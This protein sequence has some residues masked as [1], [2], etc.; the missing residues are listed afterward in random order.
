VPQDKG[1][2]PEELRPHDPTDAG[3][4]PNLHWAVQENRSIAETDLAIQFI[5]QTELAVNR[6]AVEVWKIIVDKKLPLNI[7]TSYSGFNRND[8]RSWLGFYDGISNI[9]S[10][11]RRAA[12]EVM[13]KNP[14]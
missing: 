11:E 13:S 6:A 1:G 7:V 4:F 12:I 5:A 9:R 8:H 3:P 2:G 14:P 10:D